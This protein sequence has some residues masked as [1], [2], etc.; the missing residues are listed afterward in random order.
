LITYLINK[1]IDKELC[2]DLSDFNQIS[3]DFAAFVR[4]LQDYDKGGK[5]WKHQPNGEPIN[6]LAFEKKLL[7]IN[8]PDFQV[9]SGINTDSIKSLFS[10]L[11]GKRVEAV[12]ELNIPDRVTEEAMSEEF[13]AKAILSKLAVECLD[14]R[15]LD[16]DLGV[17][18]ESSLKDSLREI[19]L[20]SRNKWPQLFYWASEQGLR[21]FP[22]VCDS[23]SSSWYMFLMQKGAH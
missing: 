21:K 19:K 9:N 14:W 16:I 15:K 2:L 23:L 20:Y 1:P 11:Q 5:R 4:L 7:Y 18:S 17:F 8:L 12:T 13:V 6:D 10:W 3:H 22:K